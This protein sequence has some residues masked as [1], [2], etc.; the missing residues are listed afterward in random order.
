MTGKIYGVG[1]GPGDAELITLKAVRILSECDVIGIPAR[2][3][4]HCTAYQIAVQAVPEIADKE[5]VAVPV[6]MAEDVSLR[7]QVYDEG[8]KS[9]ARRLDSG[10]N[11]AFL[12]LGDPTIYATYMELHNRLVAAG[13]EASIVSGVPSFCAAAARLGI[14]LG[15]GS[16]D[17]HILPGRYQEETLDVY[18]GT[19]V[20]MKS[21][22]RLAK[23]KQMLLDSEQE[24][25]VQ[26]YGVTNCGMEN[27]QVY[28]RLLDVPDH[29][30]YFSLLVV[31][32]KRAD[33]L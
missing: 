22:G 4:E 25:K 12:N 2:D 6:P 31:K 17:I 28:D 5:V 10:Q 26:V 24:G 27:E 13:Y 9:L 18:G 11:I 3:R 32:D 30:G 7:N 33:D 14:A 21:G 16:E 19:R 1:V 23:I 20:F 29:A 8:A 15:K